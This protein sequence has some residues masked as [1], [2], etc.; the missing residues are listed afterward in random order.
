MP[1]HPHH[2]ATRSAVAAETS[3]SYAS[4]SYEVDGVGVESDGE[5]VLGST[6]GRFLVG[7]PNCLD[8]SCL[9][10]ALTKLSGVALSA[11]HLKL[12]ASYRCVGPAA[13]RA[14]GVRGGS[15]KFAGVVA[16]FVATASSI[17]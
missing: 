4:S 14:D 2:E 16:G 10:E 17:H 15:S 11:D 8:G 12:A 1:R 3:E 6:R 9:R 5:L 13:G 7:G